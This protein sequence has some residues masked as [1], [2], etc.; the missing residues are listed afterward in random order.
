MRAHLDELIPK[1][2]ESRFKG[3]YDPGNLNVSDHRLR[4]VAIQIR[5]EKGL[6]ATDLYCMFWLAHPSQAMEAKTTRAF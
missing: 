6:G 2:T 3:D 5:T 4:I 1:V